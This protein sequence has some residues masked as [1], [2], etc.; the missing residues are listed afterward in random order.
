MA[1]GV[2]NHTLGGVIDAMESALLDELILT[3]V[4]KC[5]YNG[6]ESNITG[7][8]SRPVD[9]FIGGKYCSLQMF[10]SSLLISIHH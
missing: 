5:S 8:S 7:V 2:T 6:T 4:P 3:I 1:I 9:L 10:F